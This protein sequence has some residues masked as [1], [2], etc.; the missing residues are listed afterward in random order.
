MQGGKRERER[1]EREKVAFFLYF[2]FMNNNNNC[3]EE[4][5]LLYRLHTNESQLRILA[6]VLSLTGGLV[7]S[8]ALGVSILIYWHTRKS[9]KENQ[10]IT[11]PLLFSQ[12]I[13][14]P[15]APSA[16]D[17]PPPEYTLKKN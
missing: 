15:S 7:L 4:S 2:F 14:E 6:V 8:F 10:Q 1:E 13:P 11:P 17:I 16:N 3:T 5:R 12:T 9:K